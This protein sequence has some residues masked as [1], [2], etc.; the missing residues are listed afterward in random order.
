MNMV[1]ILFGALVVA[2]VSVV[3]NF[4]VFYVFDF[5]PDQVFHLEFLNS[6]RWGFLILIFFKNLI[7]GFILMILFD[8][9]YTHMERDKMRG[10]DAAIGTLFFILYAIFALLAFTIGDMLLMKSMEGMLILLTV[11]GFVETFIAT[12]PVR[13]FA[14]KR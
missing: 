14:A 4:L 5:Y 8:V 6:I 13:I 3:Y 1:K 2:I 10:N 7:V 9:A 11:D 12:I